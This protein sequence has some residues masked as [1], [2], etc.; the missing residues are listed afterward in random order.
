M[1]VFNSSGGCAVNM[2]VNDL[3]RVL[4]CS[5][6]HCLLIL[7]NNETSSCDGV[8]RIDNIS[9]SF[10]HVAYKKK[11]KSEEDVE[12]EI[13]ISVSDNIAR[14]LIK[15][16]I[17]QQQQPHPLS[18]DG[19]V[20][21]ASITKTPSNLRLVMNSN[22]LL[23]TSLLPSELA[24]YLYSYS[25]TN[26]NNN[27]ER[28]IRLHRCCAEC[29]ELW[30]RQVILHLT[31]FWGGKLDGVLLKLLRFGGNLDSSRMRFKILFDRDLLPKEEENN[32]KNIGRLVYSD[33]P[34][35]YSYLFHDDNESKH[36]NELLIAFLAVLKDERLCAVIQ[37]TKL[38]FHCD[39]E[40]AAKILRIIKF[41]PIDDPSPFITEFVPIFIQSWILRD[42]SAK[43]PDRVIKILP[44]QVLNWCSI[45]RTDSLKEKLKK[46]LSSC[47]YKRVIV[48]VQ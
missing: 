38:L 46:F 45:Y 25:S 41:W 28:L 29:T 2:F 14:T 34:T 6:T 19:F 30:I 40:D 21:C 26:S 36:N 10:C 32:N 1:T 20:V 7:G 39:E 22:C 15:I 12:D 23:T 37:G 44:L 35:I 13:L 5:D 8:L 24:L 4:L 48:N 33:I 18:A 27:L 47:L 11:N 3:S 9:E 42:F 17:Q 16:K 43:F 31:R